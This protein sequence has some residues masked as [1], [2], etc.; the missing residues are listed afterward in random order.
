MVTDALCV[1]HGAMLRNLSNKLYEKRKNA[2]LEI[3]GIVKQLATAGEHE[4][5]SV[6]ISLLINDFTYSPQATHRKQGG[7]I[8]FAAVTVGLTSDAAQQACCCLEEIHV[9]D[10]E[11]SN[12][13][14]KNQS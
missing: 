8:G 4:K 1:I 14:E 7:L 12:F 5:I 10:I 13:Q 2:V 3:E 9:K 6:V 11:Q